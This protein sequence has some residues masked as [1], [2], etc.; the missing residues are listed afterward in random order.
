MGLGCRGTWAGNLFDIVRGEEIGVLQG[1]D[2]GNE[3]DNE[4]E[5][6]E[7]VEYSYNL[8]SYTRDEEEEGEWRDETMSWKD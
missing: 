8:F 6:E 3:K 7:E 4:E 2:G 5:E 1:S